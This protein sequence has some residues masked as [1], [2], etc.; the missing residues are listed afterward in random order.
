MH[1][2]RVAMCLKVCTRMEECNSGFSVV[3][4]IRLDVT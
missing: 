1:Y 4:D 3:G 2:I